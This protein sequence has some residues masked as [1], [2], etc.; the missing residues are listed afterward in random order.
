MVHGKREAPSAFFLH[1]IWAISGSNSTWSILVQSKGIQGRDVRKSVPDG[2]GYQQSIHNV[3]TIAPQV[4]N[5]LLGFSSPL[6]P[7]A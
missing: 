2:P 7:L 1:R 4:I 5:L 6:F 3:F